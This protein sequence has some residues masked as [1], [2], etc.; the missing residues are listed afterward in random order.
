MAKHMRRRGDA[1]QR[2]LKIRGIRFAAAKGAEARKRA[3]ARPRVLRAS[4]FAKAS[5]SGP[6]LGMP[7]KCS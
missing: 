4:A 6:I 7:L 1:G 5:Y 3:A 2:K